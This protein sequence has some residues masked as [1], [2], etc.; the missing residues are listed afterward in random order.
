MDY[1]TYHLLG[2]PETTID[3]ILK[4]QTIQKKLTE[5]WRYDLSCSPHVLDNNKGC[6]PKQIFT[7][8]HG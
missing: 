3:C 1:A 6:L 5:G 8:Q 7:E 2:E 4:L